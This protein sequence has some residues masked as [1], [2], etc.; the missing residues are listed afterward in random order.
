MGLKKLRAGYETAAAKTGCDDRKPTYK[1]KNCGNFR[2]NPCS[3]LRKDG[4]R[5]EKE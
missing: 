3:C 2:Y 4:T 5:G 1:C